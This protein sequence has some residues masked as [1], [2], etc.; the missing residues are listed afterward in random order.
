MPPVLSRP[1]FVGGVRVVTT[2]LQADPPSTGSYAE[3]V[4][5]IVV[6]T[7][8][9]SALVIAGGCIYYHYRRLRRVDRIRER[10]DEPAEQAIPL[11]DLPP[12]PNNDEP[13]SQSGNAEISAPDLPEPRPV[14]EYNRGLSSHPPS[15]TDLNAARNA[16]ESRSQ[17]QENISP[18]MPPTVA[19]PSNLHSSA[20]PQSS[21]DQPQH[22]RR[23]TSISRSGSPRRHGMI[24]ESDDE[25]DFPSRT[26]TRARSNLPPL[27]T[28]PGMETMPEVIDE[29]HK[30]QQMESSTNTEENAPHATEDSSAES[31]V[32][33]SVVEIIDRPLPTPHEQGQNRS[34]FSEDYEVDDADHE[35]NEDSSSVV[36]SVVEIINRPPPSPQPRSRFSEDN[37]TGGADHEGNGDSSAEGSGVSSVI[38]IIYRPLPSPHEQ[39]QNRSHFC[40]DYE[41][42]GVD[43][44]GKKPND[45]A[46]PSGSPFEGGVQGSRGNWHF[47][48]EDETYD[49]HD[50]RFDVAAAVRKYGGAKDSRFKRTQR[51]A[52][53]TQASGSGSGSQPSK[54]ASDPSD[55][56]KS[57]D[58]D[59]TDPALVPAPLNLRRNKTVHE[60]SSPVGTSG[61][62]PIPQPARPARPASVANINE[63]MASLPDSKIEV[64]RP[65]SFVIDKWP[66]KTDQSPNGTTSSKNGWD[67]APPEDIIESSRL[68]RQRMVWEEEA[69]K[70]ILEKAKDQGE[71]LSDEDITMRVHLMWERD[72]LYELGQTTYKKPT[73]PPPPPVRKVEAEARPRTGRV[74]GQMGPPPPRPPRPA[75]GLYGFYPLLED[76]TGRPEPAFAS[77]Q[78]LPLAATMTSI[79]AEDGSCSGSPQPS[80]AQSP[81]RTV[82]PRPRSFLP[83]SHQ[84]PDLSHY[85]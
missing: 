31:S 48:Y 72:H 37:E 55:Q 75:G 26:N 41:A 59:W 5:V 73:P 57:L 19:G 83:R 82:R 67:V 39:S 16:L 47:S 29:Y 22:R 81:V 76:R 25:D 4:V 35:D 12:P 56:Y 70:L 23:R 63:V 32:V 50:P 45:T 85:I 30:S 79:T 58:R 24:F 40:Q 51:V 38:E 74:R 18:A 65:H 15:Q 6:S 44:K 28:L 2:I 64:E 21:Q 13:A 52:Q 71:H 68:A 20:A 42:A 66:K 61:N 1:V 27:P 36:S 69:K 84:E 60:T 7:L 54:P 78:A 3:K 10:G 80:P 9:C 43:H 46:A 11:E 62:L 17:S 34:R 33:S 49:P 53:D 77:S 14:N 8:S